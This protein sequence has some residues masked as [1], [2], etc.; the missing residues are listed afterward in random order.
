MKIIHVSYRQASPGYSDPQQWIGFLSFFTGIL[1]RTS[2]Y[3][4]VIA[5]HHIDYR[6]S[7]SH[8]GVSYHFPKL[9]KWQLAFPIK[10]NASI[11][12]LKPD[13]VVVHGLLFPWQVLMLR[14]QLPGDVAIIA[15]HHAEKPLRGIRKIIQ[16]LADRYVEAYL[17]AS[18]SS[19]LQWV[20]IGLIRDRSKIRE[21]M[22][23]SSPF[24]PMPK[25][26]ARKITQVV[27]EKI[28][29]WVGRLNKNKDPITV[30]RAFIA[31]SAT[32][33]EARLYM[34][35]QTEDLLTE[36]KSLLSAAAGASEHI[37]L[38]GAVNHDDLLYWYNSSDY[39][40]S[41]SYYEG[42]GIA[43][44]EG[45]SCGC[46]PVLTDIPSFRMMTDNGKLGALYPAGD[47]RALLVALKKVRALDIVLEKTKVLERFHQALSFEAIANKIMVVIKEVKL[48]REC[49]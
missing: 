5:I 48:R 38:V 30:V 19:G 31:F 27:G 41:G 24:S 6:G 46:I 26:E 47:Q 16:Q 36:V 15:Q 14:W 25:S 1:E 39:I 10:L 2:R 23:A 18:L 21:I 44:C 13:V 42:S 8:N 3:A 4:E 40:V 29:L 28:F 32:N 49:S 11:R 45:M 37:H 33:P 20:R 22:E 7:L 9:H 17:F 35:F 34:I 12:K 43:V